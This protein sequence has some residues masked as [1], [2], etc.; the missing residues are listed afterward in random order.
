MPGPALAAGLRATTPEVLR[1]AGALNQ[2]LRGLHQ[3]RVHYVA[4]LTRNPMG[5]VLR[6]A[7][8][9]QAITSQPPLVSMD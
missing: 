8:R 3:T 5:K 4:A 1:A 2:E 6:Q 9:A 7:V